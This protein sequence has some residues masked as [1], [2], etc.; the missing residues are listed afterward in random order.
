[1]VDGKW[2]QGRQEENS[3]ITWKTLPINSKFYPIYMSYWRTAWWIWLYSTWMTTY[4][5]K[6]KNV[7]KRKGGKN[8][9]NTIQVNFEVKLLIKYDL[10]IFIK[11]FVQWLT[12]DHLFE[13]VFFYSLFAEPSVAPNDVS[14][15]TLNQTTFNIS[16]SPLT[17]KESYSK[18]IS[19]EVKV[20]LVSSGSRQKRSPANSKTVNTTK[21]FVILYDI[22]PCYNVYVRA[23]TKAGPG[24]YGQ[25]LPLELSKFHFFSTNLM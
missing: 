8:F 3:C 20:S 22:Q 17:R 6:N 14:F 12:A 24:P 16:W 4:G 10:E 23:Y 5:K 13:L 19:Y 7:L 2:Y 18:V 11:F 25:P 1:M 9:W 21:A 15:S